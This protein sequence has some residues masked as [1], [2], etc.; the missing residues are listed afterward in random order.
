MKSHSSGLIPAS[1]KPG[2]MQCSPIEVAPGRF[3]KEKSN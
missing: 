1:D 2:N 3:V